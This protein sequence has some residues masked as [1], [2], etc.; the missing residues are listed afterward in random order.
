[1]VSG[2]YGE[3]WAAAAPA[4]VPL[5]LAMPV[6]ALLSLAGPILTATNKVGIELRAQVVTLAVATPVLLIAAQRS[7]AALAWSVLAVYILR[8]VLLVTPLARHVGS[9]WAEI[10]RTLTSPA[11][12][13]LGCAA[14]AWTVDRAVARMP[15]ILR[16]GADALVAGVV[17]LS[18]VWIL[19]HRLLR[20]PHVDLLLGQER[21]P[22]AVRGWIERVR[23]AGGCDRGEAE[24]RPDA[25]PSGR[26]VAG[27]DAGRN[28]N[29]C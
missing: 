2:I 22:P 3:T 11:I 23:A 7:F 29:G 1:V 4:V 26:A 15:P 18:F 27:S 5:A 21:L 16:L 28:G 13:A 17:L 19:R 12:C 20:G 6:L 8:C 10:L 14:G 24:L 9:S 25:G